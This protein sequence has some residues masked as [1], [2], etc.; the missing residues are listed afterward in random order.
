MA[1]AAQSSMVALKNKLRGQIKAALAALSPTQRA[2]QSA[3]VLEQLR[4]TPAYARARS[5]SLYLPMDNGQEVDTWPILEDLLQRGA[6]VAIPRV[7]G[8]APADMRMLQLDGGAGAALE[9][10]RSLPRTKWGIPEP[11]DALAAK[12]TD[13]TAEGRL[14]LVLVPGVAFDARC[15]RLGH[16]RGYY[17]HFLSQ[18]RAAGG[19]PPH[20]TVIGLGLAPQIVD[21]V[22][23]SAMDVP[24]DMIVHP[25]GSLAF[26][27]AADREA[28]ATLM[29][30]ADAGPHAELAADGERAPKRE[31]E[32]AVAEQRGGVPI[33]EVVDVADGT[34]KYACLLVRGETAAGEEFSFL[35]VRSAR[36]GYH[37]DVAKPAMYKFEA[38]GMSSRALGAPPASFSLLPLPQQLACMAR[39]QRA[40]RN[41]GRRPQLGRCTVRACQGGGLGWG[42]LF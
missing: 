16:G 12:M 3:Q 29:A 19:A 42:V 20:F 23:V 40:L 15:G 34:H 36:G 1:T 10:A 7:T 14:D 37:A 24:L 17:D 26:T 30:E 28:A 13:V 22:P 31:R 4:V 32:H 6:Q 9:Q 2:E 41:P 39:A 18:R 27:S 5:I 33:E 8:P 38:R 21:T 35:A 11:D 25:A